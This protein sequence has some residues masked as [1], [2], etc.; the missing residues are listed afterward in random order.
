MK[1]R[2][3]IYTGLLGALALSAQGAERKPNI[4]LIVADDL[5][6]GELTSQGF[7]KDIPTPNI[8]SIGKNGVRFTNGYVSGPY[9]SPTR[10][11]LLTGRYQERF[12]HEFNP[13]PPVEGNNAI[14]LAL[15]EKTAGDRLKAAG[16]TTGWFGKS[17]LGNAPEFHPLNRGFDEFYGFLGG[18]HSYENPGADSNN[19]I[20]R[21]REVD[22]NPGYLTEAFAREAVSFIERKKD[23]PWFV[24]LPFNAV[25]APL[26]VA[27]K[28]EGRFTSIEDPKRRKFAGLLSSLDDNVG[29]VL[30]KLKE[31]NLEE[32]TLIL[33]ISD[34]G[35][36]TE[37]TT[38]SNGPLH[39][40]KAQTWEGGIR[41]PFAIQW[42]GK[43]AAGAL[44]PRPVIQLDLLPTA[45]AAAGVTAQP[46]WK[47]DGVNLLPYV[48]D[49]KEERP[50]DALFWRFGQQLAV[51]KGDWKLV[52]G[53][54]TPGVQPGAADRPASIEGAQ[55]YN[56]ADDIGETTD[57]AAKNPDKV[58]ELAALW[59]SWNSELVAPKWLPDGR[60]AAR[61]QGNAPAAA[62]TPVA[63]ADGKG[64]WKSGDSLSAADSPRVAGK[65]FVVAAQ[66]DLKEAKGVIAAQG[67]GVNGYSLYFLDGKLA[68]SVRSRKELSSVVSDKVIP[69]GTHKIEAQVTATG[70]VVLKVDG[71]KA[72]E[73]TLKGVIDRQPGEGL[74]IGGD[75]QG[76]VGDYTAPAEVAGVV[77]DVTVTV[78]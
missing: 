55:L 75:G 1:K 12:G 28:Y 49:G 62:E 67:A 10:A 57:L 38:S 44:D 53:V 20:L 50:H 59:N 9:C 52:K 48:K 51:R 73:G 31:L 32:D 26:E 63:K 70:A 25:H 15:T 69:P 8:D 43:I 65:E 41:V 33:F 16:Y 13:G 37:Q 5:G 35:G 71:E 23:V 18:A 6:Y 78:K 29:V 68:L 4:L 17:H 34:N 47:L 42:K 22:R 30:N 21:G 54:G 56:L 66:V 19:P 40:F 45:L 39:G 60:R 58:K 61:R 7:K 3:L 36:P 46:D 2:N 11:G 76:A 64:P 72:G 77:S 24:Y 27:E 74:T 14:G